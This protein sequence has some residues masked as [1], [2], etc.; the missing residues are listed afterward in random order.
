MS[1]TK[2]HTSVTLVVG[3]NTSLVHT[4]SVI[5]TS[6]T[7]QNLCLK[8]NTLTFV[9]KPDISFFKMQNIVTYSNMVL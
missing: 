9:I 3:E 1:F 2:L 8:W 7:V 4:R 5:V 6:Q